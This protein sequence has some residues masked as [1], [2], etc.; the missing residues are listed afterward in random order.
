MEFLVT[1]SHSPR[2]HSSH[3]RPQTSPERVC[4]VVLLAMLTHHEGF[5]PDQGSFFYRARGLECSCI[6]VFR[7]R[8]W[9]ATSR[10]KRSGAQTHWRR[11]F[12]RPLSNG[13]VDS[14]ARTSPI[15]HS[16]MPKREMLPRGDS[17]AMSSMLDRPIRSLRRSSSPHPPT[18]PRC[19]LF[20]LCGGMSCA[21]GELAFTR[22]CCKGLGIRRYRGSWLFNLP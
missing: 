14:Q 1:R 15:V 12:N 22:P 18:C 13:V 16:G 11:D 6:G 19:D 9:R 7:E 3:E 20:Q 10:K 5:R 4:L 17:R 2:A 21:I 8:L